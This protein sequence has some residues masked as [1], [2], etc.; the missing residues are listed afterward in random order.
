M[1]IA[2]D[3]SPPPP[4]NPGPS[5]GYVFLVRMDRV[6]PR[7]VLELC[8]WI[9]AGVAVACMPRQRRYSRDY[10]ARALGR[11]P[12]FP[13]VWRHFYRFTNL[14]MRRL[15]A[16]KGRPFQCR[17]HE[18]AVEFVAL[19]ESGRPG[20]LGTFHMGDSD[21]L[22]FM[23]AHFR[24]NIC[25]LRLRM[26]NSPETSGLAEHSAG[27]V[28]YVWVNDPGN[29]VFALKDEIE[30]GATVAMQCDRP[31]Y[32]AKVETF[33]FLGS[34]RAFPF[35]IYHLALLFQRPVVFCLGLPDGRDG[36]LI[37][38]SPVFEPSGEDKRAELVRARAH[39]QGFLRAVERR[40]RSDP[41]LW[42]NFTPFTA[43]GRAAA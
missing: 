31:E 39:F 3:L 11:R 7:G 27:S 25:M 16:A 38:A 2:V 10:L 15:R 20:F 13:E 36:T 28:R 21:L 14:L 37:W 42:F 17:M 30:G 23:L 18:E 5:W 19:M 29:L 1:A 26:E 24:K 9:G 22:G 12:T 6:L 43:E 40:L 35:A 41:Y 32:S 4:R 33:P 34:E 8:L